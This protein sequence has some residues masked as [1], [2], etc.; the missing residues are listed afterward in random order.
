MSRLDFG[1]FSLDPALHQLTR[2][3]GGDLVAIRLSAAETAI[4]ACLLDNEGQVQ[5]KD[6]LLSTGWN[7]RPV[8]ANSLPV[9]IANLRRHLQAPPSEVEIRTLPRQGYLLTLADG[10]SLIR[11]S[12]D[13]P[14]TTTAAAAPVVTFDAPAPAIAPT[15]PP[16]SFVAAPPAR[17][18]RKLV[19]L[20]AAA[21][22]G[23]L[24]FGLV[25]AHEWVPVQC[26]AQ[27]RGTVCVVTDTEHEAGA[28]EWPTDEASR[29]IV[30]SG[31]AWMELRR[32]LPS[33][34][35]PVSQPAR[36]W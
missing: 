20:N 14:A 5:G 25:T 12:A 26:A 3:L 15:E 34:D 9:A 17:P 22:A 21:L 36:G 27:A 35:R 23:I 2:Q 18:L 29:L 28:L 10:I 13:A 33:R 19:W 11:V 1:S 7:G 24:I 32:G 16:A 4:L 30:A 31:D 6:E 8:S